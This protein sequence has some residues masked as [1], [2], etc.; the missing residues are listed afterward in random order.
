[1]KMKILINNLPTDFEL[2]TKSYNSFFN[3]IFLNMKNS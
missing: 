1:M 3:E 2:D